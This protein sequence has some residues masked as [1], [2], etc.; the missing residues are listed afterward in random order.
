M[1]RASFRLISTCPS[2]INKKKKKRKNIPNAYLVFT[3]FSPFFMREPV[4]SGY[5]E[6][7]LLF[8][9]NGRV[10]FFVSVFPSNHREEV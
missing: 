10:G 9:G 6:N 7:N 3:S 2:K 1:G 8:C 5:K 4:Y